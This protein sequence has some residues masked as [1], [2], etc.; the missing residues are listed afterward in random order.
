[1]RST[2]SWVHQNSSLC[3]NYYYTRESTF[4][5]F[6]LQRWSD[7][8]IPLFYLPVYFKDR[9]CHITYIYIYNSTSSSFVLAIVHPKALIIASSFRGRVSYCWIVAPEQVAA[10]VRLLLD[11]WLAL[12]TRGKTGGMTANLPPE[13]RVLTLLPYVANNTPNQSSWNSFL[14]SE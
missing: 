6:L 3:N 2:D 5:G 12:G 8:V 13:H 7:W 14:K 10:C 9:C 1:M 11:Q 4:K